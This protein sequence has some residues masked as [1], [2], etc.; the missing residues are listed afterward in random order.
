M[1]EPGEYRPDLTEAIRRVEDLPKP[2]IHCRN[3]SSKRRPCPRCGHRAYRD[4]QARRT[5][6]DQGNPLTGRPCDLVVIYSP[7]VGLASNGERPKA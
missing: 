1:P 7:E 2:K 5:L 4:H 6:H 3:R